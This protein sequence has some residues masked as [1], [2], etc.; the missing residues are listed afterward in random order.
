MKCAIL[1]DLDFFIRRYLKLSDISFN[2]PDEKAQKLAKELWQHSQKHLNYKNDKYELFRIYVYDCPPLNKKLHHPLTNKLIDFS[3]TDVAIFRNTLHEEIKKMP[4][5]ALRLGKLDE[6][7]VKWIIASEKKYKK[8]LKGTISINELDENDF[9]IEVNQ[10]QVD[11]KIGID[12]TWLSLKKLVDT[13]ILIS[14]D[15]DFVP[16]SKL[17]RREGI[18]FILDPLYHNLKPDLSEHIDLLRTPKIKKNK[19]KNE[20]TKA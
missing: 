20:N 10:K 3:K 6:D 7:N 17:A 12:I 4:K 9:K 8:F 19:E 18:T 2:T 1:V 14:G 11:M 13:I 15:S 5:T 16:A